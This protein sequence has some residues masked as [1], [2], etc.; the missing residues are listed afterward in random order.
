M[1]RWSLADAPRENEAHE[2]RSGHRW[3]LGR[4]RRLE[5]GDG[6]ATAGREWVMAA[7]S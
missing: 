1:A 3:I 7:R 5:V 2:V 4:S 6:G